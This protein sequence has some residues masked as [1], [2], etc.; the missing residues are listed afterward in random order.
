MDETRT[1]LVFAEKRDAVVRLTLNRPERLNAVNQSL[2]VRLA[3]AVGEANR[4]PDVRVII[5]TGAG[6]AFCAGADVKAHSDTERRDSERQEYAQAAQ[7][8]NRALQR[9]MKPVIAAVN[10]HAIGAGLELALSCDFIVVAAEA[11]LRFPELGLGT[12]VGGGVTYTLPER[13]GL[14]RA[15]E[16]LLLGDFFTGEQ[17]ASMGLA[18]EAV[19]AAELP[20]VV[21]ALAARLAAQAPV[22]MRHAKRLLRRAR[23]AGRRRMLQAEALALAECMATED[24]RE[25]LTALREKRAPR[26]QGR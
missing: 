17:A 5:V 26:Y 16:L 3:D 19:T 14:A 4:D 21:D 8:A 9:T 7:A 20:A 15:K 12:F 10:G 25:G 11:K 23:R 18:N 13:V 2:Y 1:D 6:R 24:W 22:P